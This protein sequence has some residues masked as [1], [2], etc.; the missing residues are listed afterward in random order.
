MVVYECV[1]QGYRMAMHLK[2]KARR[3]L[4]RG[5]STI[6]AVRDPSACG[7]YITPDIIAP[8]IQA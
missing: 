1:P 5:R 8:A 2:S 7:L 4:K 3:E 6:V